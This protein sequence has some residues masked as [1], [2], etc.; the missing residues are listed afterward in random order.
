MIT[1]KEYYAN[2]TYEKEFK[3]LSTDSKPTSGVPENSLFLE[4]DTGDFYYFDGEEWNK[5]TSSGGG[6][7]SIDMTLNGVTENDADFSYKV[8]IY[9]MASA[10]DGEPKHVKSVELTSG[11]S[12]DVTFDDDTTGGITIET[13]AETG[14]KRVYGC[15]GGIMFGVYFDGN[16]S[17]ADLIS[18]MEEYLD[19][20][21][22]QG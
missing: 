13:D 10:A 19:K 15:E 6:G 9:A 21:E 2:Q 4:L 1:V 11:T 3:G 12:I 22:S 8:G 20:F 17:D 16:E 7:S 5:M 18:A 14:D